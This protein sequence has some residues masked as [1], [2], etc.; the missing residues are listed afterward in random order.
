[1]FSVLYTHQKTKKAKTWQDG[2]LKIS[3]TKAVLCDEEFKTLDSL[4]VRKDQVVSGDELES[5][6]YLITIE[7][8]LCNH[9]SSDTPQAGSVNTEQKQEF[10]RSFNLNQP[11]KRKRQCFQPPKVINQS[12]PVLSQCF[13]PQAKKPKEEHSFSQKSWKSF[14]L[15]KRPASENDPFNIHR[16]F[17]GRKEIGKCTSLTQNKEPFGLMVTDEKL[18]NKQCDQQVPFNP[19]CTSSTEGK[20][21]RLPTTPAPPNSSYNSVG[22]K[23]LNTRDSTESKRS[24]AQIL[25]L[26]SSKNTGQRVRIP[27]NGRETDL[28]YATEYE[29]SNLEHPNSEEVF[30]EKQLAKDEHEFRSC[31]ESSLEQ[32]RDCQP[33]LIDGESAAEADDAEREDS[34]ESLNL[35]PD[36]ELEARCTVYNHNE[37]QQG[38]CGWNVGV[39]ALQSVINRSSH[40]ETIEASSGNPPKV[41]ASSN[42]AVTNFCT[43]QH[44]S[45]GYTDQAL[46][47][48]RISV[49]PSN[50]TDNR[51]LADSKYD[52]TTSTDFPTNS[53]KMS[54][55]YSKR[56]FQSGFCTPPDC[57]FPAFSITVSQ[58]ES[59]NL[60]RS[61]DAKVHDRGFESASNLRS[62][63]TSSFES[64][65][66]DEVNHS[67]Q[68]DISL[69]PA[70]KSFSIDEVKQGNTSMRAVATTQVKAGDGHSWK[71][72]VVSD[73]VKREAAVT[74]GQRKLHQQSSH[75][76][77]DHTVPWSDRTGWLDTNQDSPPCLLTAERFATSDSLALSSTEGFLNR[78]QVAEQEVSQTHTGPVQRVPQLLRN[79]AP[80]LTSPSEDRDDIVSHERSASSSQLEAALSSD[81]RIS[82]DE[83]LYEKSKDTD[84]SVVV[85]SDR[86]NGLRRVGLGRK[87]LKNHVRSQVVQRSHGFRPPTA[88]GFTTESLSSRERDMAGELSFPS[89]EECNSAV[90]PTRHVTVPVTFDHV[91]QYRQVFKAAVR[92]HL[93]IVLFELAR[94]YH[95][96]LRKVDVSGFGIHDQGNHQQSD[97]PSCSHGQARLRAVKKEGPNKGRL[98]YTC[99]ETGQAQC[100]LFKWADEY[101]T[102]N[103]GSR[104]VAT[105]SANKMITLSS[106]ESLVAYLRS[107]NIAFYCDCRLTRK[108][109]DADKGRVFGPNAKKLKGHRNGFNER[110]DHKKGLYLELSRKEHSSVYSKDD[111]WIISKSLSFNKESTFIASSVY[112]GPSSSRE[113]EIVP[114][115]G[116]SPSNWQSGETVHALMACN[117]G[118]ELSCI[119]NIEDHVKIQN[120]PVLPFILQRQGAVEQMNMRG[121]T[122]ASSS[123]VSPMLRNHASNNLYLPSEVTEALAEEM[124]ARFSLNKDQATALQSCA[125]MFCSSDCNSRLP[126]RLIHGVFGAGKSY[127]LAVIVLYLVELFIVSESLNQKSTSSSASSQAKIL[128]SST[129]NVAV[130]RILLSLLEMGFEEFVRVGSIRK[131]AKPVL[132]YSVH[133][134]GSDNQELKELQALLKGD[135]TPTERTHVRKSIERHKMGENK[136]KLSLVRVVGVTCAA[137]SFPHLDKLKFPVLLL[138]ECSQMTE[139]ASLLPLARF[140]C[141]RLVLV[142]DPKQL[143]PTIQGSEPEHECGLEQTMFDRLMKMGY[144]AI[145]LRTQYR[146]HPTISAV[147][148]RLFYGNKLLD[149]VTAEDRPPLVDLVPTLCFY[150]V[151]K[152]KEACGSD[153]SYYNEAEANFVVFL[154]ECLLHYGVLPAQ[155]GVITL[156]KSQLHTIANNLTASRASS[157]SELKSIQISTVDAFQ[158]GE[159]DVIIL[160]CVRTDHIGFIDC[161]RRTNVA[162]TRA[163]RHLLI[164]GNLKMLSCNALWGKVIEHCHEYPGGLCNSRE[165][166][167]KWQPS[168]SAMKE[169]P[170][171]NGHSNSADDRHVTSCSLSPEKMTVQQESSDISVDHALSHDLAMDPADC[172]L[173]QSSDSELPTFDLVSSLGI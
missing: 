22:Q 24:S 167:K 77:S 83:N 32:T 172:P 163:K 60:V 169:G 52:T 173:D 125:N 35:S 92:E 107:S 79:R 170:Q 127:L 8:R 87:L 86:H 93:N 44:Y 39:N 144:E 53:Q 33:N 104:E 112:Y 67:L 141:Q 20:R 57:A 123:F 101:Q 62:W 56:N 50:L 19:A 151:A 165:F 155:I 72:S 51:M 91:T 3:G 64:K 131:I 171:T 65:R 30:G 88:P 42:F 116:Y 126:V 111:V 158:G 38:S 147:S 5:D 18:T 58:E 23:T 146:C 4:F 34:F 145:L 36:F 97:S 102:N 37:D 84:N 85:D 149:G 40:V 78:R 6:R 28:S 10:K 89:A 142:G 100:K 11:S 110:A 128:I 48:Q 41:G 7:E 73:T 154:I 109:A 68:L 90:A 137:T 118:T 108:Y 129:T 9:P 70:S 74:S 164:I 139:P 75:A 105:K 71:G 132:P 99:P 121:M 45:Q 122:R 161:D 43:P 152:G 27:R 96:S 168:S 106:S 1:M 140:E 103:N 162:L 159:K 17:I 31:V 135:L 153:G 94:V 114:I 76:S 26:F 133:S 150:N 119:S 55:D 124:I 115:S 14:S 63:R 156:Y 12:R 160:S 47:Q 46:V 130:D 117:A 15:R 113:L 134:T 138:D 61:P 29:N 13:E 25:A 81:G 21:T 2:V 136:K 120:M 148:N 49:L 82:E 157:H 16:S 95:R 98:F 54:V 143:S 59:S 166:V 69:S 80:L 66:G